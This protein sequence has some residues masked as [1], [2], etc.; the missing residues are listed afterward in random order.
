VSRERQR[1]KKASNEEDDYNQSP[2]YPVVMRMTSDMSS[3]VAVQNLHCYGS[4]NKSQYDGN[5]PVH[6]SHS[7]VDNAE[8]SYAHRSSKDCSTSI[9]KLQHLDKRLPRGQT[10]PANVRESE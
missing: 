7:C 5:S 8:T 3:V 6:R 2:H 10:L 9:R 1:W 4:Q